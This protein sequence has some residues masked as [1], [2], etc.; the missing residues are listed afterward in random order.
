MKKRPGVKF[1]LDFLFAFRWN[2][3]GVVFS[4][5]RK[6]RNTNSNSIVGKTTCRF[7]VQVGRYIEEAVWYSYLVISALPQCEIKTS[8]KC[9]SHGYA[10]CSRLWPFDC[11][12]REATCSAVAEEAERLEAPAYHSVLWFFEGFYAGEKQVRLRGRCLLHSQK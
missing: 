8:N 5:H 10:N 1:F 6:W 7:R 3:S 4:L 12:S 9:T 2:G 11:F